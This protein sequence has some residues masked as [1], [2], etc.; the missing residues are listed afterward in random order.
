VRGH[1][2]AAFRQGIA[3]L[4]DAVEAQGLRPRPRRLPADLMPARELDPGAGGRV[5]ATS[6]AT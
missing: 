1:H 3:G 4:R 6:R 2:R 5:A